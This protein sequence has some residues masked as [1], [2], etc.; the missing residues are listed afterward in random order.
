MAALPHAA[1]TL[2]LWL[3]VATLACCG[4]AAGDNRAEA[5]PLPREPAGPVERLSGDQGLKP[6]YY[7]KRDR[8]AG[9]VLDLTDASFVLNNSRNSNPSKAYDCE[10]G[11]LP[12]NKQPLNLFDAPGLFVKGGLIRGQVPLGSD[13]EATYCNSAA[14]NLRRSPRVTISGIR[15]GNAWDGIRIGVQSP[16]FVVRNAWLSNIR[17]DAVE[18]DHLQSGRIENSLFEGVMQAV[19]LMPNKAVDAPPSTGTVTIAGSLILLRDYPFRGRQRFGTLA[20]SDHRAPA[21]RIERSIVAIDSPDGA[22]WPDYWANGWARMQSSSNNLLLWL[23]DRPPPA[24][25]PLPP[26]GFKLVT[27]ARARAVWKDARQNWINCH[28]RVARLPGDPPSRPGQC[29][30]G[31]FGGPLG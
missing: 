30:R 25:L 17:D 21:L 16:D 8:P 29:R 3:P 22:T 20:K 31:S 28:P 15:V 19:A 14:V 23:S 24:A 11:S 2:L 13:W 27:G 1:P 4:L 26:R 9:A 5:E 12:I 10:K 7:P 18:N 6:V